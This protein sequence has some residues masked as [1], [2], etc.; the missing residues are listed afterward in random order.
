M[1]KLAGIRNSSPLA[2]IDK[3][4]PKFNLKEPSLGNINTIPK[5]TSTSSMSLP[6]HQRTYKSVIPSI[7]SIPTNPVTTSNFDTDQFKSVIRPQLDNFKQKLK[8]DNLRIMNPD[9][10]TRN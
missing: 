3:S 6:R 9:A 1:P 7:H 5:K 2:N 4:K 10:V 8:L